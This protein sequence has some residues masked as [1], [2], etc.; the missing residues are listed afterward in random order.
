MKSKEFA[1]CF[2]KI[3]QKC[4]KLRPFLKWFS[5]TMK[6]D[7]QD[8]DGYTGTLVDILSWKEKHH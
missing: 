1:Q 6:L 7:L 5:N 4:R 2:P 8:D 3:F